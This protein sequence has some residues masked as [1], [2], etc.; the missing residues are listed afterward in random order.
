MPSEATIRAIVRAT[1]GAVRADDFYDDLPPPAEPAGRRV[2][3]LPEEDQARARVWA[4]LGRLLLAPPDA[5]MLAAVAGLAGDESTPIGGAL[6]RL[7]AAARDADPDKLRE[8]YDAL[9]IGLVRGELVPFASYYLTGFL[10][11]KPLANLRES[12]ARLGIALREGVAEPEDHIGAV[13]E[14]MAGLIAGDF[15]EPAD[16]ATQRRFF[17]DHIAGWAARFFED[18]EGAAAA[19]FYKPV[20]AL[21][22]ALVG[23]EAEAFEMA[24]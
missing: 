11:E 22:R 18:L 7:G 16:L 17:E 15:G 13:A 12:M 10:H 9:F 20:G 14:M 8:E 3:A 2:V 4:L 1:D 5:T 19:D 23:I 6:A 21:G 24:A